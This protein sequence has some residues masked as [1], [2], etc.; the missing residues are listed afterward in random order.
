RER[1]RTI[2]AGRAIHP[3]P[4]SI[5]NS[6]AA[7]WQEIHLPLLDMAPTLNQNNA[8]TVGI[9]MGVE[10][11]VTLVHQ[12]WTPESTDAKRIAT[13]LRGVPWPTFQANRERAHDDRLAR[14]WRRRG[15]WTGAHRR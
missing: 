1:M 8:L 10:T 6:R 3:R 15:P 2:Q 12:E 14:P 7:R 5:R 13:S 4:S 9:S 11:T